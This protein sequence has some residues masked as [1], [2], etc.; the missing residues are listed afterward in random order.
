MY[1]GWN[2]QVFWW[3]GVE[4]EERVLL[5]KFKVLEEELK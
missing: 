2:I 3:K 5:C 1:K 4:I